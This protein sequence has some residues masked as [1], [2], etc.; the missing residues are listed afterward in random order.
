VILLVTGFG[1]FNAVLENPSALLAEESIYPHRVLQVSYQEA[2]V[3]VAS[4]DAHSFDAWLMLGVASGR[5]KICFERGA[6]NHQAARDIQGVQ[7]I[8]AIDSRQPEWLKA[9]LWDE[10]LSASLLDEFP[11]ELGFSEDAGDFLC[12]YLSFLGLARFPEKLIGFLHVVPFEV[13][14]RE[15]QAQIVGSIAR[16]ISQKR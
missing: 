13:I 12:N 6:K 3:F 7:E 2:D 14:S 11:D 10:E 4:L 9:T 16:A 5:K 15:R 8:G 1:P